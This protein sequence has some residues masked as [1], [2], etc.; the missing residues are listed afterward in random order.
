MQL[1]VLSEAAAQVVAVLLAISGAVQV[2]GI[3]V[4][5]RACASWGYPGLYKK[6]GAVELLAAVLLA[7]PETRLAGIVLAA[8]VNFSVVILLLKSRAWIVALPGVAVAAALLLTLA[9]FRF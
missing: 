4:V 3:G 7:I 1:Q 5:R 8:A 9:Q 2:S 6:T